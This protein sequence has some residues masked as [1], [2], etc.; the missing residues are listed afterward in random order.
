MAAATDVE[1][2]PLPK[3]VTGSCQ[4]GK[5]AYRVEFPPDHD[6]KQN[7]GTCQCT[8]CRKSTSSLFFLY[9]KVPYAHLTWTSPSTASLKNY[10]CTPGMARGFCSECGTFLYWRYENGPHI[11]LAIGTVDPLYLFG[12]GAENTNGEVPKE[13]F[14]R[15]L[16]NCC[17]AHEWIKNEIKGVTDG[18]ELLQ[19]GERIPES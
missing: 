19:R 11:S 4:C 17:G 13:G 5:I 15:A 18:M 14:G 6:F 7:N 1:L 16:A 10:Y 9:F 12:E 2:G 3:R 8:Q